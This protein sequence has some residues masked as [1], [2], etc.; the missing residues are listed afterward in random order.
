MGYSLIVSNLLFCFVLS[1]HFLHTRL[2]HVIV[3]NCHILLGRLA[4]VTL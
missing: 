2:Y 4:L 1:H 3:D